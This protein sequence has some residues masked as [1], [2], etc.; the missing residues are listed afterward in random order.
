M[1]ILIV[2]DDAILSRGLAVGLNLS[3]FSTEVVET[4]ADARAAIA[5][6]TLSG[7]VLD[8][9]LPGG[10]GLDLLVELRARQVGLPILLLTARDQVADRVAGLD[11]GADYLGKPFD[12]EELSARLRAVLRRH[13]G[14]ANPCLHW[15]G[16]AIRPG[17]LSGQYRGE[18]LSFSS[19]EFSIL[20][21]LMERPEM[22]RSKSELEER[23]YGW[24]GD[25]ESNTV[26]VHVH[27]LR[28][29]LGSGFIETVRGVGYRL[30]PGKRA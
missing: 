2:E 16:P 10:S 26:E 15:N 29:K 12:L 17:T 1:R 25:V 14:R 7:V 11:R 19:R 21:Y 9:G 27:K 3:G 30:A 23:L 6:D 18:A 8:I 28:A 4:L 13:E 20:Q 24:T 5:D 22:I